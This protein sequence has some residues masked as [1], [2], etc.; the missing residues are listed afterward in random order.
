MYR[1]VTNGTCEAAEEV[2][3]TELG[4]AWSGELRLAS[5]EA[6]GVG[7]MP[8]VEL[9]AIGLILCPSGRQWKPR[10]AAKLGVGVAS[11]RKW[12]SGE[13]AVPVHHARHLRDL[14]EL[15]FAEAEVVLLQRA[16]VA[17]G[18]SVRELRELVGKLRIE[19]VVSQ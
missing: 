11:V 16:W 7:Q 13:R 4:L 17:R 5:R 6:N 1:P 14:V 15:R 12:A 10:L 19:T 9:R 2:R 3:M 8:A 18:L